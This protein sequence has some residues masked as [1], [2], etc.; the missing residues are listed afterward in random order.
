MVAAEIAPDIPSSPPPP[1][2][3]PPT[4]PPPPHPPSAVLQRVNSLDSIYRHMSA[5][6]P[7]NQQKKARLSGMYSRHISSSF[8]D[9]S[10]PSLHSPIPT[11]SLDTDTSLLM[12]VQSS[13]RP[14]STDS[15]GFPN[16]L[17]AAKEYSDSSSSSSEA[18]ENQLIESDTSTLSE[19]EWQQPHTDQSDTLIKFSQQELQSGL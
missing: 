11:V 4:P 3:T 13:Q 17:S 8:D 12:G 19:S 6:E 10:L 14:L 9:V 5:P 7:A 15:T 18:E 16:T 1:P 2:P